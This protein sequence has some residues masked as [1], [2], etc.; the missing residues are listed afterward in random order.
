MTP[1]LN[2]INLISI[3]AEPNPKPVWIHIVPISRLI[4]STEIGGKICIH[5]VIFVNKSHLIRS[6]KKFKLPYTISELKRKLKLTKFFD[7]DTFAIWT[8]GKHDDDTEKKFL[9]SVRFALNFLEIS[10]LIYG[11][12]EQNS[13]ICISSEKQIGGIDFLAINS[14]KEFKYSSQTIENP[15]PLKLDKHW[16][17]FQRFSFFYDLLEI[18]NHKNKLISRAWKDNIISAVMLAADSQATQNYAHAFLFNMIAI[19]TLLA[20]SSD[21]YSKELPKR[22]EAFIGWSDNWKINDLESKIKDLYSKRCKLVHAGE[23]H[24]ISLDDVILSDYFLFNIFHNILKHI[25]LFNTKEQ[26]ILFSNK[27]QAEKML[28]IKGK[29]RPKTLKEISHSKKKN[30]PYKKIETVEDLL[31]FFKKH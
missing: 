12:R 18:T 29:I 24:L 8:H 19:E 27:V 16:R 5:D 14:S 7:H 3:K 6:R 9:K 4:V 22:I 26:L 1:N 17:E 28:G 11:K 10:Q 25:T 30:T 31:S 13:V 2:G 20:E 15:I 21:T 23:L